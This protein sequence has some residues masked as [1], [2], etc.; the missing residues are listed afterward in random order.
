VVSG[1]SSS[2]SSNTNLSSS[3]SFFSSNASPFS[4]FVEPHRRR[5]RREGW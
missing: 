5:S 2:T 4:K 1:Y 3:L